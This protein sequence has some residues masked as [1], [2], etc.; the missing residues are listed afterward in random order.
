M[1]VTKPKV[2]VRTFGKSPPKGDWKI[3]KIPGPAPGSYE[4]F[5]AIKKTQFRREVSYP[6]K[7]TKN[8]SFTDKPSDFYKLP[9]PCTYMKLDGHST[10]INRDKAY[11][12]SFGFMT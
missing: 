3:P 10:I 9:G 2:L 8:K 4:D 5:E 12:K 6:K 1:T 7:T 11:T